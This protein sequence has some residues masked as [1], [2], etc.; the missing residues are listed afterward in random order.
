MR[1]FA[2]RAAVNTRVQGTAA[3]I[4]KLAMISIQS[5]IETLGLTS[6]MAI[7]VH[8]ELVFDVPIQEKDQMVAIVRKEM[9][10]A[11]QL[12]VPLTVDISAGKNWLQAH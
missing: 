7:Q 4:M 2:K 5:Q 3:D 8:D 10:S 11:V 12:S 6:K 1:Q 9:E